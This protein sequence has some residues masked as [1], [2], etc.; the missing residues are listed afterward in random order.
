MQPS[1][2]EFSLSET[3]YGSETTVSGLPHSREAEEAVIGGILINAAAFVD[4]AV[5]L[6]KGADEFYI[7]RLRFVWEAFVRLNKRHV[8]VDILTVSEELE[9]FGRLDEI[10]GQAYLTALL[11]QCPTTL[12]IEAY[13]EMVHAGHIRRSLIVAANKIAE[14]AYNSELGI[15]DVIDTAGAELNAVS[16]SSGSA[17]MIDGHTALKRMDDQ[18]SRAANGEIIW[19]STGYSGLDTQFGGG[20]EPGRLVVVA[21]APG[22]GKSALLFNIAVHQ[23]LNGEHPVLFSCEMGEEE[24]TRRMVCQLSE[25]LFP[26]CGLDT[27]VVKAGKLADDEWSIYNHCLQVLDSYDEEW[28]IDVTSRPTP[29]YV[30]NQVERLQAQGRGTSVFFDQLGLVGEWKHFGKKAEFIDEAGYALKA[31]AKDRVVPLFAAHQINRTPS[32]ESRRPTKADLNEGGE[33]PADM[34]LFI[35]QDPEDTQSQ[36]IRKI[37]C[38][39]N[40]DGPTGETPL[41]FRA[42]SASFSTVKAR[43]LSGGTV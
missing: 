15:S 21:G 7:H 34:I 37:I 9:D 26:G 16:L 28:D 19:V 1:I 6:P 23:I 17:H 40:R 30:R 10:G 13:A 42:K 38:D 41:L 36:N 25:I 18:T 24:V 32:K 31:I 5:K 22:D 12:H 4:A 8:P 11:N 27:Q 35:W 2:S 14:L 3:P 43:V 33:K 20:V 39:K 29:A